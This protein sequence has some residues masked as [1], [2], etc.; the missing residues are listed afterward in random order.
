MPNNP[1]PKPVQIKMFF[2]GLLNW[3]GEWFIEGRDT[4]GSHDYPIP[5]KYR[6]EKAALIAAKRY[7]REL[8]RTQPTEF[9]GGQAGIQD[10]VYVRGPDGQS[11]RVFPG[12]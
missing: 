1:L 8:E 6:T 10:H 5:G 3:R 11:T 7:L 4:F 9:S 12:V 2:D